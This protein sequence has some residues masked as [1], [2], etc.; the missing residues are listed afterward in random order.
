MH[1]APPPSFFGTLL[2]NFGLFVMYRSKIIHIIIWFK[3]DVPRIVRSEAR[4]AHEDQSVHHMDTEFSQESDDQTDENFEDGRVTDF[5]DITWVLWQ[6]SL[7]NW[8]SVTQEAVIMECQSGKNSRHRKSHQ[9]DCFKPRKWY[10]LSKISLHYSKK[11]YQCAR[12]CKYM[13]E[14]ENLY[15][16]IKTNVLKISIPQNTKITSRCS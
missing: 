11:F 13:C 10:F 4:R 14:N 5:I 1:D 9:N 3:H 2:A 15:A 6:S 16:R 7:L 12:L 8:Y